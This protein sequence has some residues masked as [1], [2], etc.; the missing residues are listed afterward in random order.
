[1]YD[2]KW[3]S[4]F[5]AGYSDGNA[6]IMKTDVTAGLGIAFDTKHQAASDALGI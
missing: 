3:F 2:D 4:F 5:I 1:M 6:S